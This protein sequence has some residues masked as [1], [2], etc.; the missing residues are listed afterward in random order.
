M[1]DLAY[2]NYGLPPKAWEW[3][4]KKNKERMEAHPVCEICKKRPSFKIAPVGELKASCL[5]CI[6]EMRRQIQEEID[7]QLEHEDEWW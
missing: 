3:I 4:Q 7:W 2:H 5:E 1:F 6:G